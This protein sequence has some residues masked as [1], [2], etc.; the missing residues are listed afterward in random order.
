M[1]VARQRFGNHVSLSLFG[2]QTR[3]RGNVYITYS[4]HGNERLNSG[5][6]AVTNTLAVVVS[7]NRKLKGVLYSVGERLS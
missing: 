6:P 2:R 4:Y 7:E 5:V 1:S 3:S